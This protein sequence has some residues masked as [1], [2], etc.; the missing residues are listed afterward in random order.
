MKI[1]L[2]FIIDI[3]YIVAL[4]TTL[5]LSIINTIDINKLNKKK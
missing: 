4:V 2:R 1:D 5:T 3:L